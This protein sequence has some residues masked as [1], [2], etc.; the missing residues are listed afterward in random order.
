MARDVYGN[1]WRLVCVVAGSFRQVTH[2]TQ[3]DPKVVP[4]LRCYTA[5]VLMILL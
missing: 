3:I 4:F 5:F 1:S 2:V